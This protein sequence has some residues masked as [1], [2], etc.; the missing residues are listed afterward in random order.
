MDVKIYRNTYRKNGHV[1][2][3][4]LEVKN[5]I[6]T[7]TLYVVVF[8]GLVS[9]SFLIKELPELLQN[10]KSIFENY[11]SSVS[12]QTLLKNF[13]VQL[14]VNLSVILLNFVFGLCVIGF[15]IPFFIVLIKGISIGVLSA[16]LYTEYALNGFGFCMLVFF[17]VQLITTLVLIFCGK[18][19]VRMSIG[20]LKTLTEQNFRTGERYEIKKYMLQSVFCV[21]ITVGI[22]FIS[23][24][25][26]VY[27]IRLFNF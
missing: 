14:M 21:L 2:G 6:L 17:P 8:I 23:A 22:S 3:F 19:S 24:V 9:G 11:I 25:L 1:G 13:V 12:G 16:F 5:H 15:P 18:E 27:V 10:V 20:L 4:I 7:V 26:N